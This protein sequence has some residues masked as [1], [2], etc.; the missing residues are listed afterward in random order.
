MFESA[1][2]RARNVI[3]D[4]VAR[5]QYHFTSSELRSALG[6]SEAAARQALS[7][8]AAKGEIASPARGFYV[9]VPPEYRRLGCLPADQFV[10]SL[11]EHWGIRYYVGLLSAAQYHGAA[12]HRPQEFQVVVD[13]NRPA[14]VCGA[15]RVAFVARR[16]LAA[17][18]VERVNNPRG[19]IVVSTVEATAVDLVGYMHRAGGVDRVAGVLSELGEDV[20][21]ERLVEASQSASILWAQRLGYLLEHVGA[22]DRVAPLKE[23][24][25]QRARNYTK[26]L[27]GADA[28]GAPRSK[29]WRL[30]VNASI[31]A[32][33]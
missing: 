3:A 1:A 11:M 7:R 16:N 31:E 32:D 14:I 28:T 18:P 5:G 21:P 29:D 4:L 22:G 26:L 13:K 25:R 10:P 15:V 20:D 17:V 2:P 12:H 33:A 23:H 8:L 30:L 9:I 6:V 19:T 27:P 24:V